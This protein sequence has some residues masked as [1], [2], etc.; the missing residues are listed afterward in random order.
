MVSFKISIRKACHYFLT[1]FG[2]TETKPRK[3]TYRRRKGTEE[4]G[5]FDDF[6]LSR[7]SSTTT[8]G[9]FS[10]KV[11]KPSGF[12]FLVALGKSVCEAR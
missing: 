9:C 11:R 8:T 1:F 6:F 12:A 7:G 3:K 10:S 4:S 5:L 2:S